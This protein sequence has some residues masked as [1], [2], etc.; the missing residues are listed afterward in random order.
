MN[1][2]ID[3]LCTKIRVMSKIGYARVSTSEQNLDLQIRALRLE[4]CI[5]IYTEK[6]S[7]IKERTVL[8]EVLNMLHK[9]DVLVI[10]KIDRLG[11]GTAA[12]CS[13]LEELTE[14]CIWIKSVTEG[15][16]TSTMLGKPFYQISAIF[17]EI[18]R[19]T[20][21]ERTNAGLEAA[22]QRGVRLGR[23]PGLCLG[24]KTKAKEVGELYTSGM[25]IDE[26]C[27]IVKI[28]RNTMYHYLNYLEI[29][30]RRN[31]KRKNN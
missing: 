23:P 30:Y 6:V 10:W 4:G 31:R 28:C 25:C 27:K 16:D 26:I 12:L 18:E 21:V 19:N 22:R 13:L 9:N 20:I 3:Y 14:K 1:Y 29:D 15:I 8:N 2:L 11:R 7:A 17:A 24:A 5:E